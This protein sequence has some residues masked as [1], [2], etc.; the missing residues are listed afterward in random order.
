MDLRVY[1]DGV[2]RIIC[3]LT[4]TT[5]VHDIIIALAQYKGKAG[6]YSLIQRAPDGTQRT[7]SPNELTCEL[8]HH[9]DWAY[10]LRQNPS[11]KNQ[12]NGEKR[13]KSLDER[14]PSIQQEQQQQQQQQQTF[15]DMLSP[16][17][18]SP[19]SSSNY[20]RTVQNNAFATLSSNNKK[21]SNIHQLFP[22]INTNNSNNNINL[23]D[24]SPSLPTRQRLSRTP[25]QENRHQS[26]Q[27]SRPKSAIPPST[28]S[29]NSA[30]H[31]VHNPNS[32]HTGIQ[33]Q[34]QQQYIALL[35]ILKAQEI[36]VEQQQQELNEKQKEIEYREAILRQAQ[37]YHESIQHELQILEEHDRR[38]F[39]E[40]QI[41]AQ[42]YSSD[43][44]EF[45]LEYHEKLH[46]NY[47]H[48]Q[49]QLTRCSTTLEQKRQIQD[50]LQFNISQIHEEIQQMETVITNDKKEILQ[51]QYDLERSNSSF[52]QQEDLLYILNQRND[53]IERI[54]QQDQKQI[55]EFEDVLIEFDDLLSKNNFANTSYHFH[56]TSST[57]ILMP[58]HLQLMNSTLLKICPSGIWV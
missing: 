31:I 21:R 16:V 26:I 2:A 13:S 18:S 38:L 11:N 30:F 33:H 23:I 1:V 54:I 40:C 47:E 10:I 22:S 57:G 17:T 34:Q 45:E 24:L 5:T 43:K 12:S 37:I 8:I 50:Q 44:L 3:D 28:L 35:Q 56:E 32:N 20:F 55:I 15:F 42:D 4:R 53:D 52:K 7:L 49:Q 25:I 48:L 51:Y 36:Q 58:V 9:P 41:I 39:S 29:E 6:R 19:S 27:Y 46:S 14:K